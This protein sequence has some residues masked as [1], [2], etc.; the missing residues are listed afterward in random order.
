MAMTHPTGEKTHVRVRP[1]VAQ[2]VSLAE[3]YF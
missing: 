3:D 2:F 1:L